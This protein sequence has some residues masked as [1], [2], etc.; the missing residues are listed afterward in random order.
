MRLPWRHRGRHIGPR[1]GRARKARRSWGQRAVLGLGG[2]ATLGLACSAA[3]LAYV[4]RKFERIPRIELSRSLDDVE[5]AGAPENYLLVGVDSAA[6]LDESDPIHNHRD[7]TNLTDTIM[8]VRIDP[9]SEQ[10]SIL[11]IP[12]DTWVPYPDGGHGKINGLF[13]RG[14]LRPD[15][16]IQVINDYLGLPIHHYVQVDLAGF[17]DLVDAIDGVPVYFPN[18]ARDSR[19]GLWITSSGCVTL[20]R[21]QAIA[22]VRSRHYEELVD[23]DEQGIGRWQPDNKNDFG[24]IQRQQDFIRRALERAV[25]KGARNPGTMDRLLD[26]GLSSVTIDDELTPGKIFDLARRFRSFD[27]SALQNVTLPTVGEWIGGA[28][29]Q[30]LVESEA[31]PILAQFRDVPVP[32][33]PADAGQERAVEV[34]PQSVRLAVLNGTGAPGQASETGEAL[35]ALGFSV[36]DRRDAQGDDLGGSRTV[37]RYPAGSRAQ[38]ELVARWIEADAV[39]LELDAGDEGAVDARAT[40]ELITGADWAGV[41]S[42]PRPASSVTTSTTST[43]SSTTSTTSTTVGS[44]EATEPDDE[45]EAGGGTSSAAEPVPC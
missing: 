6:R 34:M 45:A 30:L 14:G 3:G 42:E 25:S 5:E 11:S 9:S 10:A 2:L 22:Y 16:L 1:N 8:I 13:A 27:P 35:A 18:P 4:Y 19:S 37:I 15:L 40:V 7:N 17:Y 24:R 41:R 21:E 43:S 31:E 38:A 23:R 29:A 32:D 20:D 33:E 44:D 26:V 28:A 39:L 36:I 12:R